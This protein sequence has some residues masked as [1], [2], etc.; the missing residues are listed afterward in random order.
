MPTPTRITPEALRTAAREVLERD[1]RDGLTMQA[2]A[3][4]LGVRAPSLYKH[5]RDRDALVRLAA[6]EVAVELGELMNE[7]IA[8]RDDRVGCV[9]VHLAA[10]AGGEHRRVGADFHGV[11]GDAGANAGAAAFLDDEVENAGTL[12]D[13]ARVHV[14]ARVPYGFHGNWIAA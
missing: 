10:A 1:G 13:V 14:P 2:V 6:E 4:A 8:G 3:A 9:A 11:T 5:V 12:E 7:A